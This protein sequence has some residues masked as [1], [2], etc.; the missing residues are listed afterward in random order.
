MVNCVG[1]TTWG[2]VV[3]KRWGLA[4]KCVC[5][6]TQTIHG[7]GIFP[8]IYHKNQPN[9]GKYTVTWMVWEIRKMHCTRL[10]LNKG[11]ETSWQKETILWGTRF[12]LG[13]KT[14]SCGEVHGPELFHATWTF[15]K[16]HQI[17]SRHQFSVHFQLFRCMVGVLGRP[18]YLVSK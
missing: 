12:F 3:G 17:S 16:V 4:F 15:G 8:Y 6:K 7:T 1:P 18:W 13:A 14:P 2:V 9:V 10:M 5:N 11:L